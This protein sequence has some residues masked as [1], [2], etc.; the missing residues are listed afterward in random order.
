MTVQVANNL[1]DA[2]QHVLFATDTG[3]VR[4]REEGR[5]RERGGETATTTVAALPSH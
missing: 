2:R 5:E 3:S 1:S 4:E